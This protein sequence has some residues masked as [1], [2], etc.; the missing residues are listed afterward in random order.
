MKGLCTSPTYLAPVSQPPS[1]TD[2]RNRSPSKQ[3]DSRPPPFNSASVPE[4]RPPRNF[5]PAPESR[6]PPFN[7]ASVPESRPPRNFVPAS[8]SRPPPS[9]FI[10]YPEGRAPKSR[11]TESR[12]VPE[13][14]SSQKPESRGGTN[15]KQYPSSDED[16]EESPLVGRPPSFGNTVPPGP[17]SGEAIR[18]PTSGRGGESNVP[19]FGNSGPKGRGNIFEDVRGGARPPR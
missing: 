7:P 16:D 12:N 15:P 18:S 9:N 10:S 11:N 3:P 8:E 6:P 2:R 5:V 14:R 1:A 4:S 13:S 19:A 17:F